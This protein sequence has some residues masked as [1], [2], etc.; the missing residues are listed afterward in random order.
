M[1]SNP[2]ARAHRRHPLLPA[3]L[4]LVWCQGAAAQTATPPAAPPIVSLK[5]KFLVADP[6]MPDPRFASTVIFMIEHSDQ[7]AVGIVI[8]R[9][10]G[11]R[12]LAEI[13]RIMGLG[14][15]DPGADAELEVFWG[16]PVEGRKVFLLHADELRVASTRT[17]SAGIAV[18]PPQE[19]LREAAKTRPLTPM[20]LAVGYAGWA[21]GQL[22]GEIERNGWIVITAGAEFLFGT[23]H[24]DKWDRARQMRTQD[25]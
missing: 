2:Q 1:T 10:A 3:L 23:D 8:N 9:P 18:S 21:P 5:G 24:A 20:L 6:S 4:A 13:L 12:P 17:V 19:F 25:L 14:E 22:E 16:G 7:G 11:R 15:I